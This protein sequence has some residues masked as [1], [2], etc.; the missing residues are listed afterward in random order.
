MPGMNG[1]GPFGNRGCGFG[2]G[3][4]MGGRGAGFGRGNRNG[5]AGFGGRGLCRVQA[6]PAGPAGWQENASGELLQR[7]DDVTREVADLKTRLEG[8]Q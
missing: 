4:G 1:T 6:G 5:G 3:Q 2:K 7:L 8:Q